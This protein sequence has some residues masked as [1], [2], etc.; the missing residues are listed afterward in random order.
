MKKHEKIILGISLAAIAAFIVR[1]ILSAAFDSFRQPVA[2]YFRLEYMSPFG[3]VLV[4]GVFGVISVP[5][6]C[7]SRKR[8]SKG[9]EV[10]SFAYRV[11]FYCSFIPFVL[12]IAY[13]LYCM[14]HGF[15][16]LWSVSYGW[17]AFEGAFTIMGFILCIIPVLPF[18]VFWQILYIVKLIRGRKK[19]AAEQKEMS[20]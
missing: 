8:S 4:L 14:K 3:A 2:D 1:C 20:L 17:E 16:F 11:S 18:C 13:C 5:V 6:L 15:S 12:L 10:P 9:K 19:A 7:I